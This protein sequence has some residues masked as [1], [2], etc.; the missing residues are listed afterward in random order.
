M[1]VTQC[2]LQVRQWT[3]IWRYSGVQPQHRILDSQRER[4][5]EARSLGRT[6]YYVYQRVRSSLE[7]KSNKE[8]KLGAGYSSVVEYLS[9]MIFRSRQ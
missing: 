7:E 5:L 4:D 1:K 2:L 3:R 6:G 9:N 8:D